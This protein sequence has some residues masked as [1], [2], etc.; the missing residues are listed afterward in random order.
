M[1]FRS[2]SY[3][4]TILGHLERVEQLPAEVQAEIAM[5]VGNLIELAKPVSDALL[6]RFAEVARQEQLL[7]VREGAKRDTDPL[8]AAPAIS[9]AWCNARLGL[10]N[11]NLNWHSAA[12]IIAAVETF[13]KKKA[14]D[15]HRSARYSPCLCAASPS[16]SMALPTTDPITAAAMIART[17]ILSF[18]P[19]SARMC[20][21]LSV[22]MT[23]KPASM[24]LTVH[25]GG[26]RLIS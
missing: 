14:L 17:R 4:R 20:Q 15:R 1:F 18:V 19:V 9:E 13:T 3:E 24:A 5:R 12:S 7:A 10:A 23:L 21:R 8:W 6:Q 2:L 22:G 26:N 25:G 11:G 16:W